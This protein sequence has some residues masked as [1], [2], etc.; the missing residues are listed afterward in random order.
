MMSDDLTINQFPVTSRYHG[1]GTQEHATDED[2]VIVYL[3]RRFIPSRDRF[4]VMQE[5]M[6]V[7]VDRLDNIT[8]KY[9]GDPEQFWRLCDAN[10]AMKPDELTLVAG[11]YLIIPSP[12]GG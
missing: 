9:L 12:D 5:H 1:A 11:R 4:E 3:K 7:P 10:G 8:A 2:R 6:V